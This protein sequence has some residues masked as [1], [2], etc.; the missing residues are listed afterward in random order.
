MSVESFSLGQTPRQSLPVDAML[1]DIASAIQR[2]SVTIIC[3]ATGSGKS[4]RIPQLCLQVFGE[5]R[6]GHTQPRRLAARTVAARI[7][8]ECGE[9]V[10][11]TIGFQTRFDQQVSASTRLKVMTDGILLQEISRDPLLARYGLLII[12]EVHERTLNIDFLLGYLRRLLPRRPDLRVVLMSA[13]VEAE[14]FQAF[15]GDAQIIEI[16]GATHPVEIRYRPVSREPDASGAL[17]E[18]IVAAIR[19]LDVEARGDVLVFLPGE[20]EINEAAEVI[21]GAQLPS[22]DVLPLYA[23]LA[24]NEQQRVFA[25]HGRRHIILST[26]VA[27][28]SVTVPG[29]R[30]VID[31]GLARIGTYS[32]RSKLQRLPISSIS[33][34]SAT[35]RQGRC[36]RERAGICVR[37]YSEEQM[38]RTPRYTQPELLRSNLAGVIL[39]LAD[40][41]IGSL[42]AFP[43]LDPPSGN[44]I[45]DG[46]QLLRELGALDADRQ[47]L[48][49]GRRL[50]RLP[51]DPRL[52][53]MILAGAELGCVKE[54]LIIVSA[55]SAGDLRERPVDARQAADTAHQRFRDYR[56]DFLW[57][58]SA[59]EALQTEMLP[60]SRRQQQAFCATQF[61]SYRR[62]REWMD[63]H[64]ELMTRTRAM[65]L[66][67]NAE[68]ASYK[69]IHQALLTGLA[70]R[71]A[72]WEMKSDYVGCRQQRMRLHPS[73]ALRV[74]PP[75]WIMAAEITETSMTFARMTAKVDPKWIAQAAGSLIKKT[76][77]PPQWDATRGEAYVLEEQ[78]LYGLT[79]ISGRR[80]PLQQIGA[81]EAQAFFIQEALVA[82]SLGKP[83]PFLAHNLALI[84]RVRSAEERARRRDLLA[85]DADLIAFYVQRLPLEIV[86][87][88]QLVAWLRSDPQQDEALRMSE[89][90]VTRAG[91][92]QLADYL[93]PDQ[94]VSN[95]VHFPLN[96]RYAP[97]EPDDGVTVNIPI[98]ALVEV[99]VY[100]FERLVPGLLAEKIAVLIKRLSKDQRRFLSPLAEFSQALTAAIEHQPGRLGEVLSAAARRM[101][102]V[103]VDPH[104]W[105]DRAMPPHLL[106][107]IR[108]L[109]ARGME[110]GATRDLRDWLTARHTDIVESFAALPWDLS[111]L[112][113]RDWQFGTVP[114]VLIHDV[115]GVEVR[116]YPALI[117]ADD[118][119]SLAVF[120]EDSVA[121]EN[122]RAA[123]VQMLFWHFPQEIKLLRKAQAAASELELQAFRLGLEG[124]LGDD[125]VCAALESF[126]DQQALP[127]DAAAFAT[128][129]SLIGR[130]L[131]ASFQAQTALVRRL[132]FP[133][134]EIIGHRLPTVST[135]WPDVAVDIKAQLRTLFARGFLWRYKQDLPHYPR[136]LKAIQIRIDRLH[137]SPGKDL[138]RSA[139]FSAAVLHCRDLVPA[140]SVV[141]AARLRFLLAEYRVSLFAPTLRTAEKIS[142]QRIEEFIADARRRLVAG[143]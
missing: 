67:P 44:A 43:L 32:P 15:F 66:R 140:L 106:M 27:E 74:K 26:N 45:N 82:G 125:L 58:V 102:G 7:A 133:A 97:G 49:L 72:R 143:G 13:T 141:E 126:V 88:R 92:E 124:G 14:R 100:D 55:L 2:T 62:A 60:L 117:S 98:A 109:D 113:G 33:Q 77:A 64:R 41:R 34:A 96:Y 116:G 11:E 20:R 118:Q 42:E 95:G 4:T 114:A 65:G 127:R 18:A 90:I 9:C 6:V 131:G 87:R 50:A 39:R 10:G 37:L 75:H 99:N 105:D 35:Q 91:I 57:F 5:I 12:D 51:V 103:R 85:E 16:P 115:G 46:Y 128:L 52:A 63:I 61:W 119:V 59:W 70:T 80:V 40:L 94:L 110:V 139:A 30:H 93:Y 134:L 84:E 54:I 8:Q 122:H 23:R 135:R 29:V 129:T 89:A 48:K 142:A 36:G 86:T 21:V 69:V 78:A 107:R 123:I 108:L 3:G 25:P 31:S 81:A 24:N 112:K 83:L 138:Q 53:R 101:T 73:S 17:Y 1:A 19:E 111:N 22:T 136:Y 120:A 130:E 47:L 132:F 68:P 137:E 104:E 121:R 38:A 76:Y 28:T 56:S 71:I 79:I